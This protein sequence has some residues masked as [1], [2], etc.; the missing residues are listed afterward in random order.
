M[1]AHALEPI[2]IVGMGCRFP[3][4]ANS[5]SKLWELLRSPRDLAQRIPKQR[6]NLDK[7]YHPTGSH[8][9][10]TNV[11]ESYFLDEQDDIRHFDTKFFGVGTAEAE[12]MDPQHRML[13]EV[14]YEAMEHGGFT[15]SSLQNSDTAVYVGMMCTDYNI[16]LG[17]DSTFIPQYTA[18]GVSPSNASSRISYYFN[19]HGPSMTIDTAADFLDRSVVIGSSSVLISSTSMKMAMGPVTNPLTGTVSPCVMPSGS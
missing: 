4:S 14:V 2:A 11:T 12:A 3:G 9:G 19:W 16:T 7:F 15:L 8:H 6:W 5:P 13:L 1:D 10:T 18:T 17:L